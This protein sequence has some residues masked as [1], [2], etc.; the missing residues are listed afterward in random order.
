M[1]QTTVAK[2][3]PRNP[4]VPEADACSDA[5]ASA[6]TAIGLRIK[7][8]RLAR[9]MTLQSVS[10]V[11]GLSPLDAPPGR[12]RPRLAVDR[13]ACRHRERARRDDIGPR[14]QRGDAGRAS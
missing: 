8:I 14:C 12:A 5:A 9:G 11:S 10:D 13:V 3:T 4:T 1:E 7:E 6:L 2:A